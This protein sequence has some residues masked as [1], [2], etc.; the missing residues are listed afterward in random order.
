M[1]SYGDTY[2]E[3]AY[4]LLTELESSL[5]ELEK[6]PSDMDLVGRVFRAM[7]TIKGSGA[8]FGFDDIA[9]FT[10]DIE[11][12][13]DLVREKKIEV[14]NEL[15]SLTLRASDQIRKMVDGDELHDMDTA[16]ITR[17]FQAMIPGENGTEDKSSEE[18]METDREETG[19]STFRI[20][21]K[22]AGNLF[23]NGTNPIFLFN[24]LK[25]IGHV[26]I[27]AGLNDIPPIDKL[28]PEY[29][30]LYWE[31]LLTTEKNE[32][33]V[34]DVFIFVEDDSDISIE[35]V[36]RE[37]IDEGKDVKLGE[38]LL[39]R[40]AL[41]EDALGEALGKQK[42]LGE[43]LIDSNAVD[44]ATIKSALVEQHHIRDVKEEKKRVEE[45]SSLRVASEKLDTLVNLVGELVTVQAQLTEYISTHD[46]PD[47]LRIT[48]EVERLSGELRDNAM[49]I[50]MMPIGTTFNKFKRLVR[51]LSKDLGKNVELKTAG[52]ETELDK[53]VIDK[54][55]D[56]MVH[57]IRNC[58]DHGIETPDLREV[59]GKRSAGTIHLS[60][61]HS[62]GSVLIRISDDG[63]GLD[64]KA[65]RRKAEAKGLIS[66]DVDLTEKE[67]HSLIFEPGFST[68]ESVTDVSGR[69]VGMDVVKRSIENLRGT[70]FIESA[71]GD[72]TIITLKLPLTLAII[73]GLLVGIGDEYYVVPLS[74]VEECV[75]IPRRTADRA[76][77]RQMMTFREKVIPY[78]SVRD[79]L[80]S[81]T[82][83][84]DIEPVVITE[85]NGETVGLGVDNLIGQYQTV[86]KNISKLYKDISGISGATILGDGTVALI[87]D[88]PGLVKSELESIVRND[89]TALN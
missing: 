70:I 32:E 80:G 30:Y 52:G 50:R 89:R 78:L 51:D 67:I 8:M 66:P 21:F 46:C 37:L 44:R 23:V 54:L 82:D 6:N 84:P 15:I 79:L 59:S 27:T 56:P 75:K 28:D 64:V 20:H 58:I 60:A 29:C 10:H 25:E 11:T 73:D 57:I 69:G 63:A 85:V 9:A 76:R 87:L 7:H 41:P 72:G 48:E 77:E 38:I 71:E 22:P 34:R 62:G 12:V 42:R 33:S 55:N 36:D 47:L 19:E 39:E 45:T 3:E 31:I 53:T 5:L 17:S 86:I 83:P 18:I 1:E 65:I 61:V 14:T 2:R 35:E 24:E 43:I 49:S 68:A 4:E 81:K 88:V 26:T 74:A 13:Y 40:K 16:A